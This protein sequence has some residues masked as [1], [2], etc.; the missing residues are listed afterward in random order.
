MPLLQFVLNLPF[1]MAGICIKTVFFLKKGFVKEYIKGILEGIKTC[2]ACPKVPF[3][4]KNL[5]N[6][7][8][9]QVELWCNLFRIL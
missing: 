1:I 9:I 4:V 2:H 8:K 7:L 6:Y 3:S 5:K